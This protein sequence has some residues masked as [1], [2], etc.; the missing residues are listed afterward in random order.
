[1]IACHNG[2]IIKY[3]V[4][5]DSNILAADAILDYVQSKFTA[6]KDIKIELDMLR[7]LGVD[8]EVFY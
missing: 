1:M 8:I 5:N 6:R 7:Q 3:S 4:S 2:T